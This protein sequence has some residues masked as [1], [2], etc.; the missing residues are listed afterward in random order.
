LIQYLQN[1][2]AHVEGN[3]SNPTGGAEWKDPQRTTST[4][5]VS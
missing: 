2:A 1:K 3:G 5:T 4:P